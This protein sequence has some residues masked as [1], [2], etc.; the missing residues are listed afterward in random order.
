MKNKDQTDNDDIEPDRLDKDN[1]EHVWKL[2]IMKSQ[3][4]S[5]NDW[6]QLLMCEKQWTDD[7]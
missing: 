2:L 7:Y 3:M 4:A 5:I 1:I 6:K